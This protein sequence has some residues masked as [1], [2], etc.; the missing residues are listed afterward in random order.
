M[1]HFTGIPCECSQLRKA[2]GEMDIQVA[3]LT[4]ELKFIKNGRLMLLHK[5]FPFSLLHFTGGIAHREH[6]HPTCDL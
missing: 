5:Y 6:Y 2:I 3:Q 4:T 1:Y